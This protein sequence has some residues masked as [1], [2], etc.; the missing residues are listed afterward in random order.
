M[1]LSQDSH[2]DHVK[3]ETLLY[4]LDRFREKDEFFI[5]TFELPDHLP[6]LDCGLYG[7]AMGDGYIPEEDVVYTPRGDRGYASRIIDK[8][9]RP[10]RTCTVIG[11]PY[12]GEKCVL[13]TVYG[14][15]KAPLE[16]GNFPENF[17]DDQRQE[18]LLFWARH[19]LA[20]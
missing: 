5:E 19:A 8:P 10:T 9:T 16:P 20:K 12:K 13:Y 1:Y 3:S 6:T 17:P 2:T 4:V 7:P 14:G 15:P 18:A 11:G